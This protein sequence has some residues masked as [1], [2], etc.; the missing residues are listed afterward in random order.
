MSEHCLLII[1]M[2]PA[3]AHP[4]HA[5]ARQLEQT[6]IDPSYYFERIDEL[7]LPNTNR[8]LERFREHQAKVIYTEASSYF[9]DFADAGPQLRDLYRQWDARQ[10]SDAAHVRREI[11][12][13]PG[14]AVLPKP[15]SSAWPSTPIDYMLRAAGIEHVTIAGVITNGCVM[16][17][18]ISAWDHGFSV[19]VVEDAC[20]TISRQLHDDALG[21][22]RFI[23]IEI[24]S[25]DQVLQ[26]LPDSQPAIAHSGRRET[27][28]ASQAILSWSVPAAGQGGR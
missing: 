27:V 13:L 2:T 8:L 14:E 26:K 3:D 24:A 22:M 17:T 11:A 19:T 10:T 25:T 23:Q 7:V 9:D 21:L 6:G 5:F 12:P 18:A 4:D 1:D 28:D 20:A 16:T 15:S